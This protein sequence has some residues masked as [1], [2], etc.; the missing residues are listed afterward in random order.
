MVCASF[1]DHQ[2][3][4]PLVRTVQWEGKEI[5][6]FLLPIGIYVPMMTDS[7]FY[8][9]DSSP[10][11]KLKDGSPQMVFEVLGRT[12]TV[13]GHYHING[14]GFV[15]QTAHVEDTVYV[16]K[17]AMVLENS[18]LKDKVRVMDQ[19]RVFGSS[20]IDG[21]SVISGNSLVGGNSNISDQTEIS[22]HSMAI[23]N[24][25]ATGK[26]RITDYAQAFGEVKIRSGVLSGSSETLGGN[27]K[28]RVKPAE[29]FSRFKQ[30]VKDH[31]VKISVVLDAK[32][33]TVGSGFFIDNKTLVT[34]FHNIYPLLMS[35]SSYLRIESNSGELMTLT[36][37]KHL[38]ALHDL[39]I[40]EVK[41]KTKSFLKIAP[42]FKLGKLWKVV[43]GQVSIL[44]FPAFDI[45]R[46][47][48]VIPGKK[49]A[50]NATHNTQLSMFSFTK[51]D[52][53]RLDINLP[54]MKGFSGGPVLN[55]EGEVIGVTSKGGGPFAFTISIEIL[56]QLLREPAHSRTNPRALIQSEM[57]SV[58]EK[59][60]KE[61]NTSAQITLGHFFLE[62]GHMSSDSET[63]DQSIFWFNKAA[64]KGDVEA[65][66]AL[67]LIHKQRSNFKESIRWHILSTATLFFPKFSKKYLASPAGCRA[68]F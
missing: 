49:Y 55:S 63:I 5:E 48:F 64:E 22:G 19:A 36:R 12:K 61:N 65:Q 34:N 59:A 6:E 17:S 54:S 21:K 42:F 40:L 29:D 43:D 23:G 4:S 30:D 31:T 2:K 47:S 52:I 26:T 46:H 16:G 18:N 7:F 58:V 27:I 41:R 9:Y 8:I 67:S 50:I 1:A 13:D 51:G 62:W 66:K 39:A 28:S 10:K 15:A 38:S 60:Q 14:G 24:I 44:G 37:I 53:H 20:K 57:D 25:Q 35:P 45:G 3:T 33:Q 32:K 11:L 68:A 56:N